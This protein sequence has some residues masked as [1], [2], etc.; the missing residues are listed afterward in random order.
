MFNIVLL[1]MCEHFHLFRWSSLDVCMLS[2]CSRSFSQIVAVVTR[3]IQLQM[4]SSEPMT[5]EWNL[6]V[7]K[8]FTAHCMLFVKCRTH[9]LLQFACVWAAYLPPSFS[10]VSVCSLSLFYSCDTLSEFLTASFKIDSLPLL[11]SYIP[12][13]VLPTSFTVCQY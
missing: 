5:L 8:N 11:V 2:S 12:R 10:L 4:P 9:C 13:K 1:L 6:W 7:E 3:Y